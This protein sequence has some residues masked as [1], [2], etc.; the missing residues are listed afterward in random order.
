[1]SPERHLATLLHANDTAATAGGKRAAATYAVDYVLTFD[2]Y[3]DLLEET[4][5]KNHFEQVTYPN[6]CILTPIK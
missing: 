6:V 1:M 5:R 4:V 2:S 3:Y